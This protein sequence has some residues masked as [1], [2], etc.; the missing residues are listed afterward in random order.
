MLM[1]FWINVQQAVFSWSAEDSKTQ[2]IRIKVTI[3]PRSADSNSLKCVIEIL[4]CLK[5]ICEISP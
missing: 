5:D 4:Q 1:L 2:S 3:S